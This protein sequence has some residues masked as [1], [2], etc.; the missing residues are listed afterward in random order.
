MR[1]MRTRAGPALAA[2]ALASLALPL[3]HAQ[4]ERLNP[5]IELLEQKRP[6]FTTVELIVVGV[7]AIGAAFGV[8][9]VATGV[10]VI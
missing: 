7:L 10:I 3:V 1:R 6:V 4:R 9:G 8:Y 2:A 5:V